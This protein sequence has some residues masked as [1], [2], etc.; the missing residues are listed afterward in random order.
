MRNGTNTKR[1]KTG[2]SPRVVTDN[3]TQVSVIVDRLGF[4]SVES[5]LATGTLAD[6]D[7]VWTTLI[8]DGDDPGLA[9]AAAVA[10]QFL[11]S[12]TTGVAPELAASGIQTDDDKVRK[13]EYVGPKRY[14]R[15]SVLLAN[16]TGAFFI[17]QYWNLRAPHDAT[18][19]QPTS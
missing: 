15:H 5:H 17:G 18:V 8:E 10:D 16:N 9:D 1:L 2:I 14:V 3:T 7:V 12:Q 4:A 6:S 13:I 19:T 11:I